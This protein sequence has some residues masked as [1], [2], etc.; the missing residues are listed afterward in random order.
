MRLIPPSTEGIYAQSHDALH[1]FVTSRTVSFL[2]YVQFTSAY[3][4]VQW[5]GDNGGIFIINPKGNIAKLEPY[6]GNFF[7]SFLKLMH[8]FTQIYV[9]RE[10]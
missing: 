10:I 4:Y 8:L 9:S 7:L 6:L 1:L 2:A 5:W 3:V